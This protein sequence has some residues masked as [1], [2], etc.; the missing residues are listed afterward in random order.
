MVQLWFSYGLG[1]FVETFEETFEVQ[2]LWLETFGLVT[3]VDWFSYGFVMVWLPLLIGLVMVQL[4]FSFG[5]D[6]VWLPLLHG[7]VMVQYGSVTVVVW[8]SCLG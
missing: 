6:M 4:W 5:L 1:T 3:F 7:L 8:F 2:G